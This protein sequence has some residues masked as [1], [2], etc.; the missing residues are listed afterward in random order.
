MIKMPSAQKQAIHL[1]LVCLCS[2]CGSSLPLL[3]SHFYDFGRVSAE[4][5]R[6]RAWTEH[7]RASHR[8]LVTGV[9]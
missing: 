5:N 7:D 4:L 3:K 9:I 6:F 8:L 1:L 2:G